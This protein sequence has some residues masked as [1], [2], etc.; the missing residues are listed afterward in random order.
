MVGQFIPVVDKY[1]K[2]MPVKKPVKIIIA[3]IS[4]IIV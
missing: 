3:T 4:F 1:I 2:N